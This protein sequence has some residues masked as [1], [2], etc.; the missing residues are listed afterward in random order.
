MVKTFLNKL[1]QCLFLEFLNESALKSVVVSKDG[2]V[3]NGYDVWLIHL[4]ASGG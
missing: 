3:T 4:F 1:K 2:P